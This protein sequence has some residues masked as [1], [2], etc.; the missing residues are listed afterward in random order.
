MSTFSITL[1]SRTGTIQVGDRKFL[2]V[3]QLGYDKDKKDSF[4][5]AAID[6]MSFILDSSTAIDYRG[7][8]EILKRYHTHIV[9][10]IFYELLL[11]IRRLHYASG[12]V[13]RRNSLIVNASIKLVKG[14][15]LVINRKTC[16]LKGTLI[17]FTRSVFY[18]GI[19]PQRSS[20]I[21][22]EFV[23]D[24]T[25]STKALMPIV[26]CPGTATEASLVRFG[27]YYTSC[28]TAAKSLVVKEHPVSNET[29]SVNKL[30]QAFVSQNF[31]N[32]V[33]TADDEKDVVNSFSRSFS[34]EDDKQQEKL[35]E[36]LRK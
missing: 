36:Q 28:S 8:V 9:W 30:N 32:N 21:P 7:S 35:L 26:I 22:N 1:C 23:T 13:D 18:T 27:L 14:Y 4:R 6:A 29:L 2:F 12:R 20:I 34:L 5:M 19:T 33:L 16:S 24:V 31:Y 17:D 10:D 15:L 3:N 11:T 25:C